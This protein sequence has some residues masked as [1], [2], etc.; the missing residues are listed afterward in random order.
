MTNSIYIDE[1][2]SPCYIIYI[3][4]II[5]IVKSCFFLTVALFAAPDRREK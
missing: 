4:C 1:E 3:G 2:M 5:E